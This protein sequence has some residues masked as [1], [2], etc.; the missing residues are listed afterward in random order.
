MTLWC[1]LV[2]L[3]CG[4]QHWWICVVHLL[5]NWRP[6]WLCLVHLP[7]EWW[8]WLLCCM[9][10]FLWMALCCIL[11]DGNALTPLLYTCHLSDGINSCAFWVMALIWWLYV[12]HLL[13]EWWLWWLNI[14]TL[15]FW[16][17]TSVAQCCA[18]AFWVMAN[19]HVVHLNT[20]LLS[21]SSM[22]HTYF[23]NDN[24]DGS[25]V[26]LPS[27]WWHWWLCVVHFPSE[28]Q[29]WWFCVVHLP[30]EW[31]HWWLCVVCLLSEWQHWW[32]CC[33]LALWVTA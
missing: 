24:V 4:W 33:I 3:P 5:S 29:H 19:S 23:L 28:W 31:W 8:H 32:F 27:E 12:V 22:L 25:V 18:L 1:S 2:H 20:C 21:D 14:C 7:S 30:S 11:S 10:A 6:C 13:S 16:M 17:T 15:A 9:L 26:Y